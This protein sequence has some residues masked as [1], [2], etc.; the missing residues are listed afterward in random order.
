MKKEQKF[1]KSLKEVYVEIKRI[2]SVGK[3]K[4]KHAVSAYLRAVE[5]WK[6][7]DGDNT[8]R[9]KYPLNENSLV[10]DLGGYIGD[11]TYKIVKKYNC[12][13]MVFEPV[14]DYAKEISKRFA[15]NDKV[16]VFCCGLEDKNSTETIY[17][18]GTSSSVYSAKNTEQIEIKYISVKDF[19][20]K[21]EIQNVDLMKINIEGGEYS[22]LE[23]MIETKLINRINNIQIQFHNIPR[24]N[25]KKRMEA[26]LNNL[27]KT[28]KLTWCC[29]PF[30][31]ENWK[32][33]K[34]V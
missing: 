9:L 14:P 24:I 16:E 3:Y 2:V 33:R 18:N 23:Y 20:D 30:V 28:H 22:L 5:K 7:A 11:F 32:R 13:V 34:K 25:S 10:L 12:R 4:V 8:Y 19:F 21:Y 17:V 6:K 29:R 1:K 31:W 15:D 26:I 27:E